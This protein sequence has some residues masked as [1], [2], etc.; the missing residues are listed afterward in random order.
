MIQ[1]E[2]RIETAIIIMPDPSLMSNVF[3]SNVGANKHENEA[4]VLPLPLNLIALII[5]YVCIHS[6]KSRD[7]VIQKVNDQ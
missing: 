3:F 6:E 4:S 1:P 2:L 5:S 7:E